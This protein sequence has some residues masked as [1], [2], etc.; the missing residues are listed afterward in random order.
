VYVCDISIDTPRVTARTDSP[1]RAQT[2]LEAFL[3][4][5][6]GATVE[7]IEAAAST[8]F[9]EVPDVAPYKPYFNC[10]RAKDDL[11]WVPEFTPAATLVAQCVSLKRA[12]LV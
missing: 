9:G 4:P 10:Q 1:T 2:E 12:G 11:N 6:R 5:L 7:Q 8:V 3:G